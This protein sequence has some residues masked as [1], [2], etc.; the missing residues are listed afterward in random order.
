MI[1]YDMA[2]LESDLKDLR[3]KAILVKD[4]EGFELVKYKDF[5]ELVKPKKPIT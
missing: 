4:I 5:I 2:M 1:D 3:A